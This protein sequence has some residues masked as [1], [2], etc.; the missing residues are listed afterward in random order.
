V[1]S[2][3]V[4]QT[5]FDP[6]ARKRLGDLYRAHAW[7]D[8]A[9]R[10]YQ[11]LARLRPGEGD[12]LLLLSRAAADAGRVDEALRL[13]QRI[14]ESTDPAVDEGAATPA[15]LWTLVRLMRLYEAAADDDARVAIRRRVREA[16]VLRDPPDVFVA[17]SFGHPDDVPRFSLH[18]PS[19]E[20]AT[21]FEEATLGGTDA[22]ILAFRIAERE[23][24]AY[25]LDVRREDRESL[26]DTTCELMVVVHPGREDTHVVRQTVTLSTS[27][28]AHR[29][30]VGADG[31]LSEIPIPAPRTT[32]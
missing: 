17:L 13:E 24:G 16:G 23:E 28:L 27:A 30:E 31:S 22:G 29:Y 26:R 19:T 14:S 7:P 15:R 9:Y 4:E 3:I 8:D 25:Q 21:E 32:H 11:T 6:W 12:V 5:P 20:D 1:F 10:E 18:Y 2:Q